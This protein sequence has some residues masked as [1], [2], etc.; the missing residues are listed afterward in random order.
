MHLG[1]FWWLE[2][3]PSWKGRRWSIPTHF[4]HQNIQFNMESADEDTKLDPLDCTAKG[5]KLGE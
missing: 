4:V 3:L 5:L 2:N 1:Y